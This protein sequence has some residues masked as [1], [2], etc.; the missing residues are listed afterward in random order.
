MVHR[1]FPW[2]VPPW[3]GRE[4]EDARQPLDRCGRLRLGQSIS[5]RA[6]RSSASDRD[7]ADLVQSGAFKIRTVDLRSNS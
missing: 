1:A 7:R 3:L 6:I 2:A 5:L 4:V